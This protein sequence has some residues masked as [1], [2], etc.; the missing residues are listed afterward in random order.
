[1]AWNWNILLIVVI[2]TSIFVVSYVVIS[3][4][5]YNSFFTS[6]EAACDPEKV[7]HWD[8]YV[9][10]PIVN[11]AHE[12]LDPTKILFSTHFYELI[13]QQVPDTIID[14]SKFLTDELRNRGYVVPD[15]DEFQGVVKFEIIN[16]SYSTI[17]VESP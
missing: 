6:T 7:Q 2:I 10:R 13:T 5:N 9:F 1:M 8:K 15:D 4:V 16:I 14:V 11:V 17:C 12:S 3:Y